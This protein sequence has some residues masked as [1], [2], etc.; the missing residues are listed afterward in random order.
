M[1]AIVVTGYKNFEL[2]IF[3]DKDIKISFIKDV[4]KKD[5]IH[6][7]EGGVVWFLLT[8]NL[9]FEYWALEVLEEIQVEYDIQ[10]GTLFCFRDHG[11]NWNES[12]QI[13]LKAFKNVDY[14]KYSYDYYIS[15]AQLKSYQKF[16]IDH[17]DGAY[18][19]YDPENET[20]LKYLYDAM[21]E[22]KDYNLDLLT[23]EK[24]NNSL[25]N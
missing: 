18:L 25:G 11:S 17:T 6:L 9:G 5:V 1:T 4:I 24:L 3:N 23:F 20:S 21:L 15:P 12:N 10:I 22:K 13:K 8:G 14:I 16:L 2:G 19:F 7:I